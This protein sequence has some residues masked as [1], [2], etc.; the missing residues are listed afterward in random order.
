MMKKIESVKTI[1]E[2]K[3]RIKRINQSKINRNNMIMIN[4][5]KGL[6]PKGQQ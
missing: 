1:A 6:T 2:A 4:K 5:A 3:E